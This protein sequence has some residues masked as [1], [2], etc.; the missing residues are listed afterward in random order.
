MLRLKLGVGDEVDE[1][2][3]E[4]EGMAVAVAARA[5]AATTKAFA[6]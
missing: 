4:I 1:A 5:A 2:A 3:V 6:S